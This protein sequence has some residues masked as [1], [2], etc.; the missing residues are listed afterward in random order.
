[1]HE[2]RYPLQ[3]AETLRGEE[4]HLRQI[5]THEEAVLIHPEQGRVLWRKVGLATRV[6]F[7]ES[8]VLSMAGNLLT[9][10]HPRGWNYDVT[11][12]R[13]RGSSFSASDVAMFV[14]YRLAEI[15]AVSPGYFH[16]LRPPDASNGTAQ[17]IHFRTRIQTLS[18][19]EVV[20]QVRQYRHTLQRID[21]KHIGDPGHPL[22]HQEAEAQIAH[23]TL[24]LVAVGWAL[25]YE[26]K[27]WQ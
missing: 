2:S 15:R 1:M 11:D 23:R 22:T 19:D 10:N 25:H 3:V 5:R 8:E 4:Q 6:V 13:H 16:I 21:E 24:E 26:R 14:H 7:V 27:E 17:A 9:H 18:F 12:P 20:F